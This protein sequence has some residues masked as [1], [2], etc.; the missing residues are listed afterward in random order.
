[1][2]LWEREGGKVLM[3]SAQKKK[4]KEE[5]KRKALG[6][7]CRS[8]AL[9][10]S[11]EPIPLLCKNF[12]PGQ[13]GE[14]EG[15]RGERLNNAATWGVGSARLRT[16][17]E[18]IVV[19][20]RARDVKACR[21]TRGRRPSSPPVHPP[22]RPAGTMDDE[23]EVS[24]RLAYCPLPF[25]AAR[26]IHG[27]PGVGVGPR[28]VEPPPFPPPSPH[29]PSS[30]VR[31]SCS[32]TARTAR[33]VCCTLY[34]VETAGESTASLHCSTIQVRPPPAAGAQETSLLT[35]HMGV[36]P[37]PGRTMPRLSGPRSERRMRRM[38]G[39]GGSYEG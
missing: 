21:S 30:P 16:G 10:L 24:L 27:L 32:S 23:N 37:A 15:E 8:A 1:M 25:P 5:R 4:R 6:C 2:L 29:F 3:W 22:G 11:F 36:N 19:C 13:R 12:I 38:G 35:R 9:L 33:Y 34:Q 14:E 7:R 31:S 28:I 20:E 18:G 26:P 17:F 39:G